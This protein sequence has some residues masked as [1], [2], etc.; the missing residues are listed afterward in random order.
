[1]KEFKGMCSVIPYTMIYGSLGRE[2]QQAYQELEDVRK[3]SSPIFATRRPVG[4][5]LNIREDTA[6]GKK[7]ID[8]INMYS[9]RDDNDE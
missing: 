2:M 1:M 4:R 8:K 7:V 6:A 3:S 9:T 5:L